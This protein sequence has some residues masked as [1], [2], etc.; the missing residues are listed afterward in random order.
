MMNCHNCGAGLDDVP[1]GDSCP[2]CGSGRRDATVFAHPAT[3]QV[4]VPTPTIGIGY[5]PHRPWQQK[6]QD[7]EHG[8]ER[9]GSAY[10]VT[11]GQYG[12]EDVRRFVEGFF[13]DCRELADWL[14]QDHQSTGLDKATV[15]GFVM[16]DPALRL[17][18]G[19]AQTTKH[20]TRTFGTDPITAGI[21][22]ITTGPGGRYAKIGWSQPSGAKG[23][24]DALR[25]ARK[26]VDA[27]RRFLAG[28]GLKS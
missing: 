2:K 22:D 5:N 21:T 11:Q 6:G 15:M 12:N 14:W 25:L 26:C 3:A 1:V 24:E 18:D 8:L 7:I 16:T 27:W 20:H 4:V 23:S 13:K 9:I 19:I 28:R 10:D 17:A